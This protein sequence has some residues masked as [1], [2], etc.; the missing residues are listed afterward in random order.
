ALQKVAPVAAQKPFIA[1]SDGTL[2]F[3]PTA[4]RAVT[5]Q[6]TQLR[7]VGGVALDVTFQDLAQAGVPDMRSGAT[8]SLIENPVMISLK[9]LL[10]AAKPY[11]DSAVHWSSIPDEIRYPGGI[12]RVHGYVLDPS[13][14]DVFI[15]GTVATRPEARLDIDILTVLMDVVWHKGLIPAVSLDPAPADQGGLDY[16]GPQFARIVNL[17]AN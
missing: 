11:S 12:G 5:Q 3:S 16:S 4:Q 10:G 15:I 7:S 1:S 17:P 8:R 13:V 14:G 2:R 6:W 9:R